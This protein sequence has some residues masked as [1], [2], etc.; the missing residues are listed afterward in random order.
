MCYGLLIGVYI[1]SGSYLELPLS[2]VGGGIFIE[3]REFVCGGLFIYTLYNTIYVYRIMYIGIKNT[4]IYGA[5]CLC[6]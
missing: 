2:R 4:V 6:L 3:A 5:S 1:W